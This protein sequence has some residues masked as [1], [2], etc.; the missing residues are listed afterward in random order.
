MVKGEPETA[1]E[2]ARASAPVA[3]A[4]EPKPEHAVTA[5]YPNHVWHVDLTVVPTVLGGFWSAVTGTL[6]M[7]LPFCYRLLVTCLQ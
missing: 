1:P 5:K 7:V 2:E 6:P 4:P 3:S